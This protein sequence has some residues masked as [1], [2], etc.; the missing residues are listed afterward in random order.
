LDD[1]TKVIYSERHS[2]YLALKLRDLRKFGD[3]DHIVI[4]VDNR[5]M[6]ADYMMEYAEKHED[7]IVFE[8]NE[9]FSMLVNY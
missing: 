9:E 1:I 3:R 7:D 5:E 4:E 8:L 2:K 6:F